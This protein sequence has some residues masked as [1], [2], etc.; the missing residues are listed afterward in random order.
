MMN[1]DD[2]QATRYESPFGVGWVAFDG[3]GIHEVTLPGEAPP[4]PPAADPPVSVMALAAELTAY[5]DAGPWPRHPEIVSRAGST[6]FGRQVYEMVAAI[7]A[8]QSRTY[9]EIARRLGRPGA[10]RAVGRA[11]ATNPFPVII[12]CHRVVGSD[13]SLTGYAGGIEM[14]RAMLEMESSDG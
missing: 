12:P 13:G 9:G 5:Y 2:R 8:S 6:S 3:D 14:K 10:A 7:P 1:R 4:A 11:M